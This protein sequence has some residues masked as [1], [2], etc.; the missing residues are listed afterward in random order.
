MNLPRTQVYR[1]GSDPEFL[2]ARVLEWTPIVVAASKIITANKERGLASFIGVDGHPATA[3]LRPP[4]AHNIKRHLYDIAVALDAT[5]TYLKKR[6]DTRDVIIIGQPIIAQE[7]LG[8]HIHI[9]M[10]VNDPIHK[11]L[12]D[13]NYML[14]SAGFTPLDPNRLQTPLTPDL[15]A[16]LDAHAVSSSAGETISPGRFNEVMAYLILPLECWAQPWSSRVARNSRYGPT[17]GDPVRWMVTPRPDM[18]KFNAWAYVHYEYRVPSTWLAHPWLAF[19]YFAL[20]KIAAVNFSLLAPIARKHFKERIPPRTLGGVPVPLNDAYYEQLTDRL[21]NLRDNTA[22]L[23]TRD[24]AEL[25]KAL[26]FIRDH[27]ERWFSTPTSVDMIAW[28]SLL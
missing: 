14:G 17:A 12:Q 20:A 9:T 23:F 15:R 6:K 28:R 2:F 22:A 13:A 4:P 16:K 27:R 7:P 24:T 10:F 11:A 1:F 3:E 8:G 26:D 21:T 25:P 5:D 18:P 19:A